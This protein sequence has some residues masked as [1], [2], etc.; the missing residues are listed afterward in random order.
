MSEKDYNKGLAY[1]SQCE[2]LETL[3]QREYKGDTME[4]LKTIT[5]DDIEFDSIYGI[6]DEDI[7]NIHTVDDLM[8]CVYKKKELSYEV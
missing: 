3:Y 4:L 6:R 5:E 2:R 7:D 8:A 1:L